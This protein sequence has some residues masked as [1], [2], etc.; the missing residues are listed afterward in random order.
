MA[1]AARF[2][3]VVKKDT[4]YYKTGPQQGRPEDG[5]LRQGTK[6]SLTGKNIGGYVQVDAEGGIQGYVD[7]NDLEPIRS[8]STTGEIGRNEDPSKPKGD[9]NT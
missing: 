2:T 8:T 7:Q 1:D 3:H 9:A 4:P 5:T 6:V